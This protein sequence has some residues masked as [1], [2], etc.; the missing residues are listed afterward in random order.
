VIVLEKELRKLES[1][2]IK[3]GVIHTDIK[4]SNIVVTTDKGDKNKTCLR[5]IDNDYITFS[6]N[7]RKVCTIDENI[8]KNLANLSTS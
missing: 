2:M 7:I 6:G 8:T 5:L 3:E 1:K 4:A